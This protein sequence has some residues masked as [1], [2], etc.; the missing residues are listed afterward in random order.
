MGCLHDRVPSTVVHSKSGKHLQAPAVYTAKTRCLFALT[1]T[2]SN[3]LSDFIRDCHAGQM[4]D[5]V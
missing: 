3:L 4:F 5:R 1:D 2:L